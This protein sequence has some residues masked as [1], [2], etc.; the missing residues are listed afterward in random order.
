MGQQ[1]TAANRWSA[2]TGRARARLA[3]TLPLL[4]VLITLASLV[5]TGCAGGP[6]L[7]PLVEDPT[8]HPWRE[9]L[10]IFAGQLKRN[11]ANLFFRLPEEE[12]HRM[13]TDL[14]AAAPELSA[15]EFEI[16]LR[17]ILA[18][19]GDSHT[20]LAFSVDRVYPFGFYRFREGIYCMAALPE[21][22]E[23]L[24][25]RLI[26]VDGTPVPDMTAAVRTITPHDN[27]SQLAMMTP[28]YLAMPQLLTALGVTRSPDEA[29]FTFQD[30]QGTRFTVTASSTVQEELSDLVFLKER[31][32]TAGTPQP[33]DR[34][35]TDRLYWQ[36]YDRERE[37]LY[38]Q[39]NACREDPDLPVSRFAAETEAHLRN[40]KPRVVLVDLR[41]NSGGDSRVFQP[42]IDL[43]AADHA[44]GGDY[45]L[46]VAIG[47]ETFSS[48]VLN[49]IAL[50]SDAGARFVGEPSGGRPNHYG[51]IR[52][53]ELPNLGRRVSYST[54]YFNHY[55]R[56]DNAA[57]T[58]GDGTAPTARGDDDDGNT[59]PADVPPP[60]DPVAL[61]PAI[62]APPSF[63]AYVQGRDPVVEAVAPAVSNR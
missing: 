29:A 38:I 9:D 2:A 43:L 57:G 56:G 7:S 15:T 52:F 51:E 55:R 16:E 40:D 59:A 45:E 4:L 27:A 23:A 63:P 12:F 8:S 39:Y 31:L 10:A 18:R 53:F 34:R 5:A 42:V 13:V 24:M 30:A 46:Y 35:H 6:A 33:L 19:I 32:A 58:G 41:R 11:H 3:T 44:A 61:F 37:L 47:R 54:R 22:T 21:Y 28:R 50:E 25:A 20:N 62:S 48:A 17:K 36:T 14:D 1:T 26:A 60:S 49:A